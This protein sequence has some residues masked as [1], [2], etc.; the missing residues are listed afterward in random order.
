[1][2]FTPDKDQNNSEANMQLV[3]QEAATLVKDTLDVDGALILDVSHFEIMES[4]V[5]S[6]DTVDGVK[7]LVFYHADLYDTSLDP[8]PEDIPTSGGSH[9]GSV[10]SPAS[11][12]GNGS[13]NGYAST[14]D[15]GE[16]SWE[17][18]AIPALPVLGRAEAPG[19][20]NPLRDAPLSGE[21]HAKI[22]KFLT[23]CTEGKIYERLPSCFRRTLPQDIE[24]AMG[25]CIAVVSHIS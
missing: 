4:A 9:L 13:S 22:S 7:R 15:P 11:T 1:M 14:L 17:F 10:T 3:Y 21:D 25:A 20:L 19:P 8:S 6:D 5:E 24:Y 2:D 12:Y 18:G 16:P 23:T